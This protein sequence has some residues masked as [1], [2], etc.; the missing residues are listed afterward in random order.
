ME[1]LFLWLVMAVIVALVAKSRGQSAVAWFLYGLLIWPIALVHALLLK[2][3]P[4]TER[5]L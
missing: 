4:G 2:Q 3:R 1:I 5:G